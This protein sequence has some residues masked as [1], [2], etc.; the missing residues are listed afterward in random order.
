MV[1][2]QHFD[3][4]CHDDF[5]E[6][7]L[8]DTT[9]YDVTRYAEVQD[10]LMQLVEERNSTKLVVNFNRI[11]YCSTALIN[12]VLKAQKRLVELGGTMKLCGM[13]EGVGD[14]FRMLG[15][16]GTVFHVYRSE[17]EALAAF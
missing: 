10:E 17:A 3:I 9:Y 8:A 2:F 1:Q 12:G 6:L 13:S 7:R 16:D 14:A 15:L 5:T 4:H 11:R